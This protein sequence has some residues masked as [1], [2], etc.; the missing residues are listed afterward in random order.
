MSSSGKRKPR[1][2]A[3]RDA[4]R[5]DAARKKPAAEQTGTAGILLSI[6]QAADEFGHDRRTITKR[7]SELQI[8]PADVR[9]GHPVYRLRD[10]LAMERTTPD[11]EQDPNKMTPFERAAHYK[12]EAERLKVD[13][14]RGVLLKRE[15]VETEWSRVL[16]VISLE[17]STMI[18]VLERDLGLDAVALER[19][20]Q[21]VDQIRRQMYDS[22]IEGHLTDDDELSDDGVRTV[23]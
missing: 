18:D 4:A 23:Q 7:I 12:A 15:D 16:K 19:I 2:T 22:V 9:S 6:N 10:L 21:R 20:E 17:L 14:Q 11:G 5:K 8:Q 1:A 13:Q 3:R